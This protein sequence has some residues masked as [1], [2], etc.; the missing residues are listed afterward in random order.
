MTGFLVTGKKRYQIFNEE[1]MSKNFKEE[2][3]KAFPND[4]KAPK[5]GYPD[6][7]NGYYSEK[8]SYKDWF[9]FNLAQRVQ[10]NFIEQIMIVVFVIL[11]AGI[12]YPTYTLALGSLYSF[13]RIIMA[14]GYSKSV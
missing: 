1:F 10:G 3:V 9:E 12:K 8:L 6:N 2:H 11:V 4:L 14:I 5:G 13:G 7:G